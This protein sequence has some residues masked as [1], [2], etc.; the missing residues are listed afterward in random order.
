MPFAVT[1]RGVS[2][3]L[4]SPSVQ[5]KFASTKLASAMRGVSALAAL[6][7]LLLIAFQPAHAQTETP[8]VTHNTWTSGAAMPTAV[9]A[10]QVALLGTEIY[11]VGGYGVDGTLADTQIYS[12]ATN[13]WSTGV[14]LPT[15]TYEG[16]AAVVKN[17]LYVIGGSPA[18]GPYSTNAVWAYSPKTKT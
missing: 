8:A 15:A 14:P 6:S 7:A 4:N 1:N 5:S 10:P 17:I 2:C 16:A 12:P 13:T 3:Y 9:V 18:S 11:V